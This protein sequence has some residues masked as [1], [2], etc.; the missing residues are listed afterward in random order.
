MA[1]SRKRLKKM[2]KDPQKGKHPL[3]MYKK[4]SEANK[5]LADQFNDSIKNLSKATFDTLRG[6][7][8]AVDGLW[9]NQQLLN[10]GLSSAEAHYM[11]HRRVFNDA[12]SGVT[13]VKTIERRV[14]A[15]KEAMEE[16]QL[17]DWTGTPSN[18]TTATTLWSSWQGL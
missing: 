12:L 11:I 17:I 18:S 1:K 4:V 8:G 3:T 15:G 14:E 2:R 6:I 7:R 10:S 16:V 5:G 9:K 13:R